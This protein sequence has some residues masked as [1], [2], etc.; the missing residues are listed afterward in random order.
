[1]Q[2]V[3]TTNVDYFP[4]LGAGMPLGASQDDSKS[5]KQIIMSLYKI[6]SNILPHIAAFFHF[7]K[8]LL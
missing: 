8:G 4:E 7:E 3:I 6:V 5:H 1:M 2:S